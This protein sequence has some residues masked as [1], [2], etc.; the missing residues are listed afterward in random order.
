MS[1]LDITAQWTGSHKHS[2]TL[3][4]Y[5]CTSPHSL[6]T[7]PCLVFRSQWVLNQW[8]HSCLWNP[9]SW[10]G[11]PFNKWLTSKGCRVILGVSYTHILI[12]YILICKFW[13]DLCS[14]S[15]AS[16]L[17][18]EHGVLLEI[19][20]PGTF[21]CP[22]H[23]KHFVQEALRIVVSFNSWSTAVC[24]TITY[25]LLSLALFLENY[26]VLRATVSSEAADTYM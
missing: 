6:G 3:N 10:Y 22:H 11:L 15:V 26:L 8:M 16:C 13:S 14:I 25:T 20:T 4:L 17:H 1:R 7:L 24:Q 12:W 23:D 9:N 21:K 5:S 2:S 18:E 19:V